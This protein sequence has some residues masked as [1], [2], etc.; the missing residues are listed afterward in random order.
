MPKLTPGERAVDYALPQPFPTVRKTAPAFAVRLR[1]FDPGRGGA[2]EFAVLVA[3]NL[4]FPLERFEVTCEIPTPD[5]EAKTE[6][7]RCDGDEL[8]KNHLILCRFRTDG[9]VPPE[10]IRA[11]VSET[12]GVTE[13]RT[14]GQILTFSPEDLDRQSAEGERPISTL[15]AAEPKILPDETLLPEKAPEKDEVPEDEKAGD[16]RPKRAEKSE[17]PAFV[18]HI[19]TAAILLAGLAAVC[20]LVFVAFFGYHFLKYNTLMPE[21]AKLVEAGHQDLADD[22]AGRTLSDNLFFH[23]YRRETEDTVKS[24]TEEGRFNEALAI[25]EG[26]PFT[27]LT[28]EVCREAAGHALS[29]QNYREAYAY[30]ESAPEPFGNEIAE[31]AAKRVLMG[32]WNEEIYLVALKAESARDDIAEAKAAVYEKQGQY[33]Q[34]LAAA[35]MIADE[36]RRQAWRDKYDAWVLE[37]ERSAVLAYGDDRVTLEY[38]E[39]RPD[40]N[41]AEIETVK[42]RICYAALDAG[43]WRE[44]FRLAREFGFP[45]PTLDTPVEP[46]DKRVRAALDEF[47]FRLSPEEMRTYHQ[48]TLSASSVVAAVKNG[49]VTRSEN[50]QTLTVTDAVSVSAGAYLTSVLRSDGTVTAY[51]NDACGAAETPVSSFESEFIRKAAELR[52]IVSVSSGERHAAFLKSDGTVTV[53]GDNTYGQASTQSWTEIAAVTCGARFTAGLKKDG[54][55]VACGSD[56]AGQCRVGIYHNAIDIRAG[57]QSLAI[58]F[59]DG[60]LA[61]AGDRSMG[62]SDAEDFEKVARIR[63]G[64]NLLVAELT[65]GS[66]VTAGGIAEGSGGADK[67][68]AENGWTRSET[69]DFDVGDGFVSRQNA[70]GDVFSS[71]EN[72]P[73]NQ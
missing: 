42:K 60:T 73:K 68:G 7:L 31:A 19:I 20:A 52:D 67:I 8:N 40:D 66:F 21:V 55:L 14:G 53:L 43:N 71:G 5:G 54:T 50:G 58:L 61:V 70:A 17:R 3:R 2:E 15:T 38:L 16:K 18:R 35:G 6:I 69:A 63:A 51:A 44:A 72:V 12:A 11:W 64:L 59:E 30:A 65:D 24:L 33:P 25:S 26:A 56:A 1:A 48:K 4:R 36:A 34:M 13:D 39:S 27:A 46:E 41:A 45:E 29:G 9:E 62:L 57:A 28:E 49:T 23:I 22:F 37:R 10:K 47:Y 32:D